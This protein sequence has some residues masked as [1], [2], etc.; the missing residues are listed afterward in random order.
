[1][2]NLIRHKTVSSYARMSR[3]N[4]VYLF[5]YFRVVKLKENPRNVL[6]FLA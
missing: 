5:T 4:N 2:L 6:V 3:F 1:M